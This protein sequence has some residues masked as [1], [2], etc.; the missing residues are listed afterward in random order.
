M[1]EKTRG[2]LLAEALEHAGMAGTISVHFNGKREDYPA[3]QRECL[4][5]AAAAYDAATRPT[6]P[7]DV[8]AYVGLVEAAYATLPGGRF[9]TADVASVLASVPRLIAIIRAQD[10]R[11]Q[12]ASG[13]ANPE[14]ISAVIADFYERA[15]CRPPLDGIPNGI[16]R[17]KAERNALRDRLAKLEKAARA[18]IAVH[19]TVPTFSDDATDARAFRKTAEPIYRLVSL[20]DA[21][22][23]NAPT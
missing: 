8:E 22:D 15:E 23:P 19:D 4:D 14:T 2:E 10:A 17:I 7:D 11:W 6:L 1:N 18:V 21:E 16:D 13:C 3:A 5:E 12:R 20:L 9:V